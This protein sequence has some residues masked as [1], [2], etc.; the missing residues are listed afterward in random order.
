M[1]TE[2]EIRE[3]MTELLNSAELSDEGLQRLDFLI[4]AYF[5]DKEL[6]DADSSD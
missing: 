2:Q 5:Q 4:Y 3:Q 1:N 6:E